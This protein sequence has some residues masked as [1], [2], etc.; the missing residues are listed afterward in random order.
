MNKLGKCL[1]KLGLFFCNGVDRGRTHQRVVIKDQFLNATL[2]HKDTYA[3]T[4]TPLP[5][6]QAH[7]HSSPPQPTPPPPHTHTHAPHCC[8]PDVPISF[9]MGLFPW[10]RRMCLIMLFLCFEQPKGQYGHAYQYSSPCTR[11]MWSIAA[12]RPGPGSD[13]PG[14]HETKHCFN[15]DTHTPPAYAHRLSPPLRTHTPH[16]EA[17]T[18]VYTHTHIQMRAHTRTRVLVALHV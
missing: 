4:H 5:N 18:P 2:L 1:L 8:S 13:A 16:T 3:Q 15:P 10:E 14:K 6:T 11:S 17:N 7:A 12:S 9:C